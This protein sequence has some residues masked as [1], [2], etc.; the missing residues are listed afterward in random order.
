MEVMTRMSMSDDAA[1]YDSPDKGSEAQI[2]RLL[3]ELEQGDDAAFDELL[4]YV[5]DELRRLAR[6]VRQGRATPTLNTT[7]LVHEAYLKLVPEHEAQFA[8]RL[9]FMRVA[10]RAMRQVLVSAYR[11]RSAQRRG[12]DDRP[13]TL[14]EQFMGAYLPEPQMIALED[15]LQRLEDLA[16][17]QAA[18]VECRFFAGL[19]IPE[20]AQALGVSTAT[21]NRDWRTARAWLRTQM[22][23]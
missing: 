6:V 13:V 20:T 14:N 21:V 16:P 11:R 15:A 4:P 1:F 18:V 9:H 22:E 2:T 3:N 19:T 12:G 23:E 7:A 8:G 10:A 17:R 5:Y